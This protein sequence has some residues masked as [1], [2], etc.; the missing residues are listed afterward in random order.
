MNDHINLVVQSY[1]RE[2]EYFRAIFSVWSFY[3]FVAPAFRETK[4]LLYTDEPGFFEEYLR[5]LP[6]TYLTMTYEKM[7]EMRGTDDFLHRMKIAIIDDAFR[8]SPGNIF[9]VDSDTFFVADPSPLF[10]RM[11]GKLSFMHQCEYSFESLRQMPLP[12]GEPFHAVSKHLEKNLFTMA[13]GRK[14]KFG[15]DLSS[16]NAGAMLLHRDVEKLLPDVFA[17]TDQLYTATRN[18]ASEQYAFSLVLQRDTE[19]EACES[20]IHHY[21]YRV[22]KQVADI[23]LHQI[24]TPSWKMLSRNAK[25]ECVRKWTREFPGIFE[26]HRFTLQDNAIQA[27]NAGHMKVGYSW[28]LR[29]LLRNPFNIT[30][31]KDVAYHTRKFLIGR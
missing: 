13:D 23:F 1:G 26:R 15:L 20:V 24:L 17:I 8:Q 16:W 14:Q 30:F 25:E 22:K 19:I 10:G 18:H 6:V 21:W 2:N 3:A 9:Y 4:T 7:K 12:S 31:I 28:A 5:D 11:T 27:F 29:L